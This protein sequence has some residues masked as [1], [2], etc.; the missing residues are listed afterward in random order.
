[1]DRRRPTRTPRHVSLPVLVV[2]LAA[3]TIAPISGAQTPA[4]ARVAAGRVVVASPQR[5]S[6]VAAR[7]TSAIAIDGRLDLELAD[8]PRIEAGGR[9]RRQ[10]LDL[11]GHFLRR[12]PQR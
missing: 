4:R 12:E 6:L 3:L 9:A 5:R 2:G 7:A 8:E 11:D 1:M 10:R